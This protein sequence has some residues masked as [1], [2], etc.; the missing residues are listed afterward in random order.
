MTGVILAAGMGTRL[1]LNE[2]KGL[3]KLPG[4]ETI[5]ERQIRIFTE[6]GIS[7]IVVVTGHQADILRDRLN[8]VE[9]AFNPRYA[10]TNTAKSLLQGLQHVSDDAVVWANGDVV[11]DEEVVPLMLSQSQSSM[12]VNSARCG[13]EEVKYIADENGSIREISKQLEQAHGEALGLNTVERSLRTELIAALAASRDTDYF[14]HAVQQLIRQGRKFKAVPVGSY[15]CIEVDFC[16][17]WLRAQELF[18]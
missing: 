6:S 5:L 1:G 2:P 9:F 4:G 8:G 13:E 15:R 10:E 14:E 12:L 16:E 17:D 7:G 3:L 18:A 11:F